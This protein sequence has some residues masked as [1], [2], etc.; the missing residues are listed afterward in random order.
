MATIILICFFVFL[1]LESYYRKAAYRYP[2]GCAILTILALLLWL[3][4]WIFDR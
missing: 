2:I 4:I 1:F 3:F